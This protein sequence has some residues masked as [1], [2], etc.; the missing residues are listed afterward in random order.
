M[1]AHHTDNDPVRDPRVSGAAAAMQRAAAA[2]TRRSARTKAA[3]PAPTGLGIPSES[4][5]EQHPTFDDIIGRSLN[6]SERTLIWV[7]DNI[8]GLTVPGMSDNKRLTLAASCLHIA[9]EHG[10]AIVILIEEKC[11]GSALAL[12]RP[13][14]EAFWRGLW[15]RYSATDEEVHRAAEDAFPSIS[16]IIQAVD[17][18]FGGDDFSRLKQRSWKYMCSYVHTGAPQIRARL[19]VEGIRSNYRLGDLHQALFWSN[20]IQL[21][22]AAQFAD[23]AGNISLAQRMYERLKGTADNN[24]AS[25]SE[26]VPTT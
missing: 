18:S 19:S 11:F 5:N 20:V 1:T 7:A 13:L 26:H 12:Q 8:N 3:A 16:R 17:T 2:A 23:A 25:S 21:A 15:L 22:S 24:D 6:E 14:I 9:I 4:P 10:Q